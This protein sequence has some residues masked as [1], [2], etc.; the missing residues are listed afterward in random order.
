MSRKK[1][2]FIDLFIDEWHANHFPQWLKEARRGGEFEPALAFERENRGGRSLAEWCRDNG[3][4]PAESIAEIVDRCDVL[5]VLAPSNPEAHFA[6]AELPLQSGKPTYID[7]PFAPDLAT[8]RKIF[9]L[10]EQ[11]HTPLLSSSALRFSDELQGAL[12]GDFAASRPGMVMVQGGGNNFDEYA[13]H[14]LEMIV[15]A[16]GPGARRAM[17]LCGGNN[18]YHMVIDYPDGRTA[19]AGYDVQ[20]PFAITLSDGRHALRALEVHHYF[21]NF[22]AAVLEFFATGVPPVPRAETLEIAALLEAGIKG[23]T[24]PGE[25]IELG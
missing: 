7:K 14:Q 10:A 25:W 23:K 19:A 6:L 12:K 24:R 16:L 13:I 17:Q 22:T 8:A 9:A 18:Q 21:E 1:I 15:A 11:H 5:F 2:G 4:R 20:F 3:V